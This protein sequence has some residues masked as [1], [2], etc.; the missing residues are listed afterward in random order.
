MVVAKGDKVQRV[1]PERGIVLAT[2][3]AIEEPRDDQVLVKWL[4][5][6]YTRVPTASIVVVES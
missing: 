5:A 4:D 3:R 6:S 1:D 2:G